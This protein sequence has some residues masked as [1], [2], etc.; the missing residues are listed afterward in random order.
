MGKNTVILSPNGSDLVILKLLYWSKNRSSN[1]IN[2]IINQRHKSSHTHPFLTPCLSTY[3]HGSFSSSSSV[4]STFLLLWPPSFFFS[5]FL[6]H[7]C[8]A[9]PVQQPDHC[10]KGMH[11]YNIWLFSY[12]FYHAWTLYMHNLGRFLVL[13]VV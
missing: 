4:W 8:M 6:T 9:K 10:Y 12:D 1:Y 5:S 2:N 13:N 11:F 3:L 7:V